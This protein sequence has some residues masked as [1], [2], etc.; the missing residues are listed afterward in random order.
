M[1]KE[2]FFQGEQEKAL[3]LPV[4]PFMDRPNASI[5]KAQLGFL[6]YLCLPLFQG[7]CPAIPALTVATDHMN[8]NIAMLTE[9]DEMKATTDQIMNAARLQDLLPA[10][11]STTEC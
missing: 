3:G 11:V 10:R 7:I 5:P 8:D 6:K 1:F 4:T 2:F 9:L